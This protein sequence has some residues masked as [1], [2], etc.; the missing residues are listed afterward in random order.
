MVVGGVTS[1]GGVFALIVA[2]IRKFTGSRNRN[3]GLQAKENQS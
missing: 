1:G 2:R 3:P